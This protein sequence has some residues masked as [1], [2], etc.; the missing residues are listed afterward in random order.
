MHGKTYRIKGILEALTARDVRVV[1]L[2]TRKSLV[3]EQFLVHTR[4]GPYGKLADIMAEAEFPEA[5][6]RRERGVR[7]REVIPNCK[8]CVLREEFLKLRD[9]RDKCAGNLLV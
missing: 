7:D 9:P 3:L 4:T 5:K 6:E 1:F 2:Q 8:L